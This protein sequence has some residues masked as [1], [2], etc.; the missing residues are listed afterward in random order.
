VAETADVELVVDIVSVSADLRVRVASA[1]DRVD[2]DVITPPVT[3][4]SLDV[5]TVPVCGAVPVDALAA[6][7]GRRTA[8]PR[9]APSP[10][11][12]DA[13]AVRTPTA[14]AEPIAI[15][16]R[17]SSNHRRFGVPAESGDRRL[18]DAG[19]SKRTGGSGGC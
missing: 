9:K 15:R 6:G 12:V 14:A 3:A 19:R 8:D 5:L 2:D 10:A 18:I 13:P 17:R 1:L 4:L 11:A 16:D 7:D